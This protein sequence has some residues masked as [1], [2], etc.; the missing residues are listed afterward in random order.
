MLERTKS[1]K[2][3]DKKWHSFHS[4]PQIM[5]SH[6]DILVCNVRVKY[7]EWVRKDVH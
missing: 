2:K 4:L 3:R 1:E 5:N 6:T 7:H